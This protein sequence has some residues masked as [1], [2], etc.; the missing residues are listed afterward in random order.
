MTSVEQ[1]DELQALEAELTN[2]LARVRA[3]RKRAEAEAGPLVS[4][5]AAERRRSFRVITGG[6][7]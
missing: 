1:L 4:V 3:A 7:S 2:A 5:A 6:R